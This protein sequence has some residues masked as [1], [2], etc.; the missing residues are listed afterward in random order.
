MGRSYCFECSKCGYRATVSGG[1][2]CG[3]QFCV[4]TIHCRDCGTL[5]DAVTRLK[6]PSEATLGGWRKTGGIAWPSTASVNR[7]QGSPPSFADALSRLPNKGGKRYR[8][9]QFELLCPNSRRHRVQVWND[10]GKCPRCGV[11]LDKSVLPYRLWD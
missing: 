2:D 7:N 6:V 9:L 5:Y 8:W 10:P 3:V 4:Q 1:T 11:F